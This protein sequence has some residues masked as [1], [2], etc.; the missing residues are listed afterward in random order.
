MLIL[1]ANAR[2]I[3]KR[4][5]AFPLLIFIVY[6]IIHYGLQEPNKNQVLFWKFKVVHLLYFMIAANVYYAFVLLIGFLSV[7]KVEVQ[8]ASGEITLITI[9]KRETISIYDVKNYFDTIHLNGY[10]EWQGIILNL[11]SKIIIQIVG[12]NVDGVPDFKK[13][14]VEKAI[15]CLGTRKMKFPFN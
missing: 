13:Y 6:L 15:P 2:N 12:Q 9:F 11:N 1:K 3:V 8:I 7:I 5:L 10:N 14:L 4:C